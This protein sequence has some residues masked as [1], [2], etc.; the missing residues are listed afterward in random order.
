MFSSVNL[1][2]SQF[3]A[4]IKHLQSFIKIYMDTIKDTAFASK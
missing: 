4:K 1:G 2:Q 3:L